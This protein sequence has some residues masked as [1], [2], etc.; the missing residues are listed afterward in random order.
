MTQK[1]R[2]AVIG[3]SGK[4]G[5]YLVREL[6]NQGYFLKLLLRHPEN[7]QD[8]NPNIEVVQG[9]ARDYEAVRVLLEGCGAVVSAL[10]QPAGQP[11][12]FSQATQNVLRAMGEQGVKRY[13][14]VSGV[15]V[16]TPLDRKSTW[17]QTAT[18]WMKANYP[19][20]TADKQAECQLLAESDAAWTLVRSPWIQLTE[21]GDEVKASREDC[22][23]EAVS[24]SALA[25]FLVAQLTSE[26]YLR[27]VPFVAN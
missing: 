26:E 4:A 15:A 27:Q 20:T 16:D 3:G 21:V 7:F 23:G 6:L 25:R 12:V 10:G 11:P 2:I 5:K 1:P 24:A 8:K 14:L 9:D 13:I 17:A 19:D 18:D 22:P